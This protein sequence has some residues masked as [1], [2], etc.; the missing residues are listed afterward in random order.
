[1]AVEFLEKGPLVVRVKVAYAYDKSALHCSNPYWQLHDSRAT[2]GDNLYAPVTTWKGV[3]DALREEK[4]N[5][6][7]T[8]YNRQYNANPY[9]VAIASL[10][11]TIQWLET[12]V[13]VKKT[14]DATLERARA[15]ARGVVR[16]NA[17]R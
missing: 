10:A 1:M 3:A 17:S 6:G 4:L 14:C 12:G 5:G 13:E 16:A 11:E 9:R 2:G 8:L 15:I 7:K